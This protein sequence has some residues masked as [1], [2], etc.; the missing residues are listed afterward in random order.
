M[1]VI[2]IFSSVFCKDNEVV[3]ELT[4]RT[5]YP[6]LTDEDISIRASR[7]SGLSQDKI[8]K[9]FQGHTSVFNKFTRE[10]ER[11]VAWLRMAVA[12]SLLENEDL[13]LHGFASHLPARTLS[14]VL[15]VCLIGDVRSRKEAAAAR[16]VSEK[17]AVKLMERHDA[18]RANWVR[19][20]RDV[21]DPWAASLYD[22]VVPMDKNEPSAA[23]R[24]I[25][26]QLDKPA[27]KVTSET[28]QALE[29]FHLAC[30]VETILVEKGHDVRVA[31]RNGHVTLTI[32]KKVLLLDR[33]EK[34]LKSMASEVAGVKS[35]ET[36]VGKAFHQ[37]DIYRRANFEA[38]SRVLLVDDEREFAQTLSERLSMREMG[39][40]AVYSGESALEMVRE[41]EPEVMVLDLKMPGID[42]IEVLRRVKKERPDVEVV[43]LTGHG[44]EK[45][46]ETCMELGA[47]AY[48]Q[49]PV[50]ID[51]LSEVLRLANEK[52]R[53][54]KEKE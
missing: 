51:E 38:P 22:L 6:V 50:D 17:E 46:R 12:D 5:G 8:E 7:L 49:K 26:E 13:V 14:H 20:V 47:F 10:K 4:E 33:L 53:Q 54:R 18:D 43:I 35:V 23:A 9:T 32:N 24:L 25:L 42:G 31:A 29:D 36:K 2:S 11:S 34:E 28:R 52:V 1:S 19:T 37:A 39:T 44:S 3:E 27:L 40:H 21:D 41:D 48:L 16:G 30:R 15:R 45:D